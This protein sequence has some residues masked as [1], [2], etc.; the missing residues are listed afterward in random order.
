MTTQPRAKAGGEIGANGLHYA[1]GEFIATTP[2]HKLAKRQAQ[3]AQAKADREAQIA[4]NIRRNAELRERLLPVLEERWGSQTDVAGAYRF[5]ALC[6]L[7]ARELRVSDR[8]EKLAE[9][10]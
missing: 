2:L 1:G 9:V 7:A 8:P 5:V 6:G 3:K 10:L 4:E